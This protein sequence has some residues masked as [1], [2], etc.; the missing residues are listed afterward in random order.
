MNIDFPRLL[1]ISHNLFDRT[2]NVGKTLQSLLSKWP[3][4]KLSSL[5][6]RNEYPKEYFCSNYFLLDD[7]D[8]LKSF[9]TFGKYKSGIAFENSITGNA[10]CTD[11]EKG[12]YRLGNRRKP[13]VSLC[14]DLLWHAGTWKNEKLSDW[15]K[16]VEPEVVLFVPNDYE[17]AFDVLWYV[18]TLTNAKVITFYMDDVFY[19]QQKASGIN[20][21][22]RNRLFKDGQKCAAISECLFT[23]CK[24]MSEEYTKLFHKKCFEFGNCI[25]TVSYRESS[26]AIPIISYIGNLHSNRWKSILEIGEA[27]NQFNHIND[28]NYRLDIYSASDLPKKTRLM[29]ED[30]KGVS[31]CG[32]LSP[33]EVREKQLQS[34]ILVHVESMDEVSKA[35]TRLSV[36]TKIFEYLSVGRAIFAY[37]PNDIASMQYLEQTGASVN[38][39]DKSKL[40]EKLEK[41][42]SSREYREE[43]G[44]KG[45]GFALE[46]CQKERES[47]RFCDTVIGTI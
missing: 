6:F 16:K 43:L 23:T 17:L 35:S 24:L 18:K 34:D 5:Y 4:D 25:D 11:T 47:K 27:I 7:K 14:R 20:A 36:S 31:F 8:V 1:V 9:L 32:A 2:N 13:S 22:R 44:Q 19:Y 37:G 40:M 41:L 15:I 10:E 38:C 3:Q 46:H 26:N 33:S 39:Y 45:V 21:I 12:L 28:A 29:I 42:L 30:N